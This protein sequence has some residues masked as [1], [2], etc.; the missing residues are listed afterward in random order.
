MAEKPLLSSE[1]PKYVINYVQTIIDKWLPS[2]SVV[3]DIALTDKGL[4]IIEFNNINSSGFYAIDVAK[5][6]CAIEQAYNQG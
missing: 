2:P 6:V 3:I 5:Y 1:I 4:K